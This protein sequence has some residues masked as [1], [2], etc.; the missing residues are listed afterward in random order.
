MDNINEIG[1]VDDYFL[2]VV[3][4]LKED[5]ENGKDDCV[6]KY[7]L[8]GPNM[9]SQWST[10]KSIPLSYFLWYVTDQGYSYVITEETK[11][12][13]DTMEGACWQCFR[14]ITVKLR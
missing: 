1:D 12:F 3:E 5:K 13:D 10:A 9:R 14:Y 7:E 4:Q 8:Y 6:I 2:K 11:Q